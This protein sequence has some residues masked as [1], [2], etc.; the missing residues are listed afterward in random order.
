MMYSHSPSSSPR[1][2]ANI[3]KRA[4]TPII[5]NI[6]SVSA[7]ITSTNNVMPRRAWPR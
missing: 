3:Q 1:L 5:A 2:T 6:N 7:I 4:S